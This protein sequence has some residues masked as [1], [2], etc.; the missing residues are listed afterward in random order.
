MKAE[1]QQQEVTELGLEA[2]FRIFKLAQAFADQY[3]VQASEGAPLIN[4]ELLLFLAHQVFSTSA[5]LKQEIGTLC[6]GFSTAWAEELGPAAA[7]YSAEASRSIVQM[8]DNTRLTAQDETTGYEATLDQL[9]KRISQ[10]TGRPVSLGDTERRLLKKHIEEEVL[11]VASFDAITQTRER[12][13]SELRAAHAAGKI[14]KEELGAL[15]RGV[16]EHVD[17]P[18]WKLSSAC[19]LVFTRPAKLNPSDMKTYRVSRKG[20]WSS[21]RLTPV[22][23]AERPASDLKPA[24]LRPP[25]IQQTR[26]SSSDQPRGFWAWFGDLPAWLQ[27][28]IVLIV[29][30]VLVAILFGSSS[31]P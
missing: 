14:T 31:M 23:D 28:T 17:A 21:M 8:Y 9:L 15:S 13:V 4:Y 11:F 29:L 24:P 16:L 22:P 26:P 10:K 3:V 20:E 25:P 6:E 5:S 7:D 19:E 1:S 18:G 27:V 2:G 30:N 12:L